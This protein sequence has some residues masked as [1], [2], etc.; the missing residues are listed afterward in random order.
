MLLELGPVETTGQ[1]PTN[2]RLSLPVFVDREIGNTSR[3]HSAGASQ[4]AVALRG[5]GQSD[6]LEI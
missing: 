6:L 5:R 1:R 2:A 4:S 3:M